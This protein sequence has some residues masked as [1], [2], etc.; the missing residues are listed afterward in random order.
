MKALRSNRHLPG[1]LAFAFVTVFGLL[2]SRGMA[3]QPGMA[4]SHTSGP[5]SI[6]DLIAEAEKNNPEIAAA[7]HGWQ[8]ATHV[9][10]QASALPETQL[11]IQQFSVGSPRPFAGFSNSD[12]AYIG[13]G[14]SQDIPYP[15]KR[16]LRGKVAGLE[17]SSMRQDAESVRRRVIESLKVTYFQLA[18]IQQTLP[19]IEQ[20]D[21]TLNQ[22]E[23]IAESHYRVGQG[24]QQDV[25]KA[26]LQHTR[27][28]EEIAHHHQAE[29]QLQAQLKQI[30]NRAQTSPDIVA[31]PLTPTPLFHTASQLLV[32]VSEESPEIRSKQ[33]LLAQQ[34]ARIE[35]AHKD[36]RPDFMASYMWQ[37]TADQFRDY[38]M[39][40]FGI[41]L[42]NRGRQ[43][44]ELAEAEEKR[45]QANQQLQAERQRVASEIQQQYV[46]VRTSEERLN[47]Y[48][49]GLIPQADAT[50]RAGMAA[51][52]ANRQDF[53]TL[54]GN[55]LDVLNLDLDY[56]QQLAEHESAIARLER[57]TGEAR[58]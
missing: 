3:Q 15:G 4:T 32:N 10:K 56:R 39:A 48:K 46:L 41:R 40:T 1:C 23:Q 26:Q 19:I 53:Q 54:L 20:S 12:F 5:T 29:G 21:H 37:H 13:F 30:L 11:S 38:Y 58:P 16:S 36:A 42:P 24:N 8:A 55:F 17:A 34:Q 57:L 28:L 6:T 47:I 22:I 49:G 44:G 31:E 18:Y 14:A 9:P 2:S 25:L 45:E 33:E 43:R 7:Y 51:Y 27:I 50:F 35:L 52:Q